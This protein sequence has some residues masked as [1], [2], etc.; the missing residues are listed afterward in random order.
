LNP[1]YGE[2]MPPKSK[3]FPPDTSTASTNQS[4]ESEYSRIF[5]Y[6]DDQHSKM[7]LIEMLIGRFS[8]KEINDLLEEMEGAGY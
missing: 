7:S 2:K 4:Q 5:S 8:E 1:F 3:M 6:L